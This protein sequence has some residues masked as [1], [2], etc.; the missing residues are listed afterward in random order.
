MIGRTEQLTRD[1]RKMP[2]FRQL[3]PQEAGVGWPMPFRKANGV[4]VTL[5]FFGYGQD[6]DSG[7]T[8]VYPPFS[9]VT[10]DWANW[11]AME[12]LDLRYRHPW[13]DDQCTARAGTFPHQAVAGLSVAEYR[14]RRT[15]MFSAYDEI[16]GH[17][18]SGT[19]VPADLGMRFGERL[20]VLMEPGLELYYRALSPQF[21]GRFL[22]TR[23]STHAEPIQEAAR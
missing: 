2:L 10:V 5:L 22:P 23:A 19:E 7:S 3:V 9:M 6:P 8:A 18:V 21:F 17:L 4:Y 15:E 14:E 1:V 11:R 13:P 12:Y 20:R 16:L